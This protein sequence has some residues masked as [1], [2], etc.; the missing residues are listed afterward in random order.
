MSKL[1]TNAKLMLIGDSII[2]TKQCV[3]LVLSNLLV[4][5]CIV[6]Y[7]KLVRFSNSSKPVCPLDI[8]KPVH[9]V[10]SNKPVYHVN[11]CKPV[12]PV[13]C[14]PVNLADICKP[15]FVDF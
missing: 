3:L 9:I 2:A 15:F 8:R 10:N 11:V 6:N 14:K 4:D 5:V 12:S 1:P 13:V 7:K